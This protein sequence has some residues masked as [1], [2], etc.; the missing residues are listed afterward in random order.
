M[1]LQN[2]QAQ[3]AL[4]ASNRV[5]TMWVC[6]GIISFVTIAMQLALANS[7]IGPIQ[8]LTAVV[9]RL[10]AGDYTARARLRSGDELQ[11]LGESFNGMADSLL[12]GRHELEDKTSASP[13]SRRRCAT[14]M[15]AS[16]SA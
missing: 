8:S 14:R 11:S 16:R 10:R 13:S 2:L 15:P 7:I 12:E 5:T 4:E 6:V 9:R 1:K 3:E